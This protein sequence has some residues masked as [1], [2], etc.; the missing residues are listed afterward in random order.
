M[1]TNKIKVM[2]KND[3]KLWLALLTFSISMNSL[4][5]QSVIASLAEDGDIKVV[6]SG[7]EQAMKKFIVYYEK[8]TN[9]KDTLTIGAEEFS[10]DATTTYLKKNDMAFKFN[11]DGTVSF[12]NHKN[13]DRTVLFC[14]VCKCFALDKCP[15]VKT[16]TENGNNKEKDNDLLPDF[17]FPPEFS[18]KGKSVKDSF[19]DNKN[20]YYH[21]MIDA[22]PRIGIKKNN[23]L[24]VKYLNNDKPTFKI[25]KSL[26]VNSS[27]SVF[28]KNFNFDNLENI[29]IIFNGTDYQ[30]EKS[31]SDIY[32]E[33]TLVKT[34]DTSLAKPVSTESPKK[35]TA[36]TYVL[37]L[38][39]NYLDSLDALNINDLAKL[40]K[41]KDNLK[42]Y[43]EKHKDEFSE[44][45]IELLNKILVWYPEYVSLN[46]IAIG[47]PDNDEA[48]IELIIKEKNTSENKYNVGTYYIKGK[49]GVVAGGRG[50]LFFTNLKNHEA[51]IDSSDHKARLD[52]SHRLSIG[53]G[54]SGIVSFR[55]GSPVTPSVNLGFFVPLDEDI[56]P[57]GQFGPGINYGTKKVGLNLSFGLA[58]GKVND[59]KA[60]YKDIDMRTISNLDVNGITEKVWKIGWAFSLG[61]RFNI[62]SKK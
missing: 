13:M 12:L 21:L 14:D 31:L 8:K 44:E 38:T 5:G 54:A 4:K 41:Y 28:I 9:E 42:T 56:S 18:S 49:A 6:T 46:P 51:Y 53:I 10:L 32:N 43:F 25:A 52:N 37:K 30:Y 48:D 11:K 40:N 7:K 35:D 16:K 20:G 62:S 34:K 29:N 1:Q 57:F 59:I 24:Y 26:R 19:P 50:S 47:V 45:A 15:D 2:K 36:I 17:P 23:T 60:R 39:R 61:M 27:L 58:F 55:T 3:Y 22:D 33:V